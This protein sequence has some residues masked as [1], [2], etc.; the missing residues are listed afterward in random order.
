[1]KQTPLIPLDYQYDKNIFL[2]KYKKEENSFAHKGQHFPDVESCSYCWLLMWMQWEKKKGG[3]GGGGYSFKVEL[4][5]DSDDTP[6]PL[7]I[8]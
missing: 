1:M 3:G 8:E 5:L 7:F 4:L 2:K 6:F